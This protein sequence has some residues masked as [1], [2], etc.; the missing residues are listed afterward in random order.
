MMLGGADPLP[1]PDAGITSSSSGL[2]AAPVATGITSSSSGL[3]AAPVATG[4][5]SSSS[6]LPAAPVATGITFS[7]SGL[8][9][10]PVAT[11]ITSLSPGLPPALT[12]VSP[13]PPTEPDA[14]ADFNKS[15]PVATDF[16]QTLSTTQSCFRVSTRSIQATPSS[17]KT[18]S[19]IFRSPNVSKLKSFKPMNIPKIKAETFSF[20]STARSKIKTKTSHDAFDNQLYSYKLELGEQ[21]ESVATKSR[22]NIFENANALAS[23][24]LHTSAACTVTSTDISSRTLPAISITQATHTTTDAALDHILMSD[25][26]FTAL[27]QPCYD[28]HQSRSP[29]GCVGEMSLWGVEVRSP[30]GCLGEGQV[31]S[32]SS[33]GRTGPL[34]ASKRRSI[35]RRG[36][37]AALPRAALT[38]QREG[39]VECW[40]AEGEVAEQR[41][42]GPC[43]EDSPQQA[44]EGRQQEVEGRPQQEVEGKPPQEV[45][46]RPPQEVE[47]RPQQA[48]KGRP[49]QA[50]EDSPPQAI[51]VKL[52]LQYKRNI[53]KNS[54]RPA[55]LPMPC[56]ELRSPQTYLQKTESLEHELPLYE[57]RFFTGT[58][59][60]PTIEQISKFFNEK[61]SLVADYD[62]ISPH[63][64]YELLQKFNRDNSWFDE[65]K[66]E[67]IKE[68]R[69]ESKCN[70]EENDDLSYPKFPLDLEELSTVNP[71]Q[72]QSPADY[73][74]FVSPSVPASPLYCSPYT[75]P[76]CTRFKTRAFDVNQMTA[77]DFSSFYGHDEE[78][79]RESGTL[80]SDTTGKNAGCR[81]FLNSHENCFPNKDSCGERSSFHIYDNYVSL[82]PSTPCSD[83]S[84]K[85]KEAVTVRHGRSGAVRREEVD[86]DGSPTS[87][88]SKFALGCMTERRPSHYEPGEALP[89]LPSR[90]E[91]YKSIFTANALQ[92]NR[93]F[94][95]FIEKIGKKS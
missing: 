80:D 68:F 4:I 42:H 54:K 61:G 11:G 93:S 5:T 51:E 8:P 14:S 44:V 27:I 9:A 32:S 92:P 76:T 2:P 65:F 30:F 7:S 78:V 49:Q 20:F 57:N 74:N 63:M 13:S 40:T 87:G 16:Q 85:P 25:P 38:I 75:S 12:C 3:P 81:S 6:G 18:S 35:K 55:N 84:E 24:R 1:S 47:G 19:S 39:G 36:D 15:L 86:S 43:V 50:V 67:S 17:P 79:V 37:S 94:F 83:Y 33:R 91:K 88:R 70:D 28:Q 26:P 66:P 23:E 21:S 59:M 90:S 69:E 73:D 22:K 82:A 95:T 64:R 71:Q 77:A 52:D 45:E 89:A 31:D 41:H 53:Q 10:A 46:G 56:R 34:R 62:Y 29:D 60:T 48:V 72:I 58:S